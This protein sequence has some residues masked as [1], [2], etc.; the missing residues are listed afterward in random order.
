LQGWRLSDTNNHV[1]VKSFAGA[2]IEDMEDYLKPIIRKRPES[3]ILHVGTN[4]LKNLSPKQV[5]EGF[6]NL[7]SQINEESQSNRS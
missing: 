3:I 1:V 2:T 7:G 5:A 6:A 4:D